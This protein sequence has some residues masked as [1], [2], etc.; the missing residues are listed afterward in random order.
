LPVWTRYKWELEE[1]SAVLAALDA[2]IGAV[3]FDPND[4]TSIESAIVQMEGAIYEKIA[5]Y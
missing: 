5:S 3:R 1:T 2:E 4:A